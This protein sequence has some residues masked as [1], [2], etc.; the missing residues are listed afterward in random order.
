MMSMILNMNVYVDACFQKSPDLGGTAFK[1]HMFIAN[2]N[3]NNDSP[4]GKLARNSFE[5]V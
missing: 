5:P 2:L 1:R 4:I 3:D